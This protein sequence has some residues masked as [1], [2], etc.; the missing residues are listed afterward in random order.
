[1]V[2]RLAPLSP[3]EV[4]TTAELL[5]SEADLVLAETA[6]PLRLPCMMNRLFFVIPTCLSLT[7]KLLLLDVT[8][9]PPGAPADNLPHRRVIV[10]LAHVETEDL[11]GLLW[12]HTCVL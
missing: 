7:V 11:G 5:V 3:D 9:V 4:A 10:P 6:G 1:M 2:L 8:S 12:F